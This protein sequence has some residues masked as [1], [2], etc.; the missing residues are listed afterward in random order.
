MP[1][2]T[3]CWG[4]DIGAGG[5]KG[6][7]LEKDGSGGVRL[8]DYIVIPHKKVLSTPGLDEADALK[9]SLGALMSQYRDAL[10]GSTIVVS[11]P[12]HSAFARFA[13]L[14]PVEPKQI[15][16]LVKFEAAQ[17]IPF[18][19]EEVEWDFQVFT[20]PDSPDIEVGIFAITKERVNQKLNLY[21]DLGLNPDQLTLGPVAAYN[22]VAFDLQFTEA[23]PGTIVL[24]IGTVASDLIIA[25]KGR[26][27]VRTFP[28]GGHNF[29]EALNEKFE[30]GNY[31][32][33]DKLKC[34]AETSKFKEHIFSGIK[35]LLGDLVQEVQRSINYYQETHPESNLTRLVGVGSTFRLLGLRKLL[36][37]QTRLDV[38]RLERFNRISME[39]PAAADLEAST[40]TLVTAYGLALQG[41]G[42]A[43]ISA[44]LMPVSVI[45]DA[46]WKR[47]MPWF[48]TAAGLGLAASGVAF[49]RPFIESTRV[50]KVA[51]DATITQVI[52]QGEGLKREWDEQSQAN[53]PPFLAENVRRMLDGRG[54][55]EALLR[56]TE[57]MLASADALAKSK[58]EFPLIAGKAYDLVALNTDYVK[59]GTAFAS[60]SGGPSSSSSGGEDTGDD[61]DDGGGGGAGGGAGGAGGGTPDPNAAGGAPA[62]GAAGGASNDT[63][64]ATGAFRVQ[65][66]VQSQLESGDLPFLNDAL[67]GWLK[68][69]SKREAGEGVSYQIVRVPRV[70][71]V[72]IS[73]TPATQAPPTP[74]GSPPPGGATDERSGSQGGQGGA[75]GSG[76]S[77]GTPQGLDAMAPL[78][79]VEPRLDPAKRTRTYTLE[80]FVQ[81]VPPAAPAPAEGGEAV[82]A[83]ASPP[84][85]DASG[86]QAS[87]QETIS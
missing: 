30:L 62:D 47:K 79:K 71:D 54:M 24:D 53:Q 32:K 74:T 39:G 48:L 51:Q 34:E 5:V 41:L 17:Q 11:A 67:L 15:P 61:R 75:G 69:N 76:G 18:P 50:V 68:K 23:T 4:I 19:M 49:I 64:S 33:A 38:V 46:M 66:V 2:S 57:A 21:G 80:W 31:T 1:S 36:A 6:V 55:H 70:E 73:D 25:E 35:P 12:G 82:P 63:A 59:P 58:P 28:I 7:K 85:A 26:V 45:R 60:F 37:S 52:S 27:W 16:N 78:P 22:A 42:L 72:K 10:R 56:D 40:G 43:P 83:S 14:P 3:I 13:K 81:L 9:I 20:S 44:N 8:L 87:G 86:Q 84:A 65:M 29:T 77:S